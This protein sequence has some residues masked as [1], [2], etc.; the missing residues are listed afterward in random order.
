MVSLEVC[1]RWAQL[2]TPESQQ[3]DAQGVG[4]EEFFVLDGHP[5]SDGSQIPTSPGFLTAPHPAH[6]VMTLQAFPAD[7]VSAL[8]PFSVRTG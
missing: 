5:Y 7:S 1:Q 6:P 2:S 3:S 4:D 8:L